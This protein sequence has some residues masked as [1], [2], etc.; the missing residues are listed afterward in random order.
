MRSHPK[1]RQ[2]LKPDAAPWGESSYVCQDAGWCLLCLQN[3][4]RIQCTLVKTHLVSLRRPMHSSYDTFSLLIHT[5]L[6]CSISFWLDKADILP[7]VSPWHSRPA[8][9]SSPAN[10]RNYLPTNRVHRVAGNV[11]PKYCHWI[12]TNPLL[13]EGRDWC[14]SIG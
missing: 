12:N 8:Q 1:K 14:Y 6:L 9:P 10:I 7:A 11:M 4:Q 3:C 13:Q 5:D 2:L